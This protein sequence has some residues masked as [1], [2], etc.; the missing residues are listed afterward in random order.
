[1]QQSRA[2]PVDGDEQAL[3]TDDGGGEAA[4]DCDDWKRLWETGGFHFRLRQPLRTIAPDQ[5]EEYLQRIA[6]A[7]S[8]LAGRAL[9]D[10]EVG[11]VLEWD[12]PH[13]HLI[14][15]RTSQATPEADR[16]SAREAVQ[17]VIPS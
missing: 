15:V 14:F 12:N 3:E 1:M 9:E 16:T 17:R 5:A 11:T 4:V 13:G 7:F 2:A 10:E 8:G 6:P